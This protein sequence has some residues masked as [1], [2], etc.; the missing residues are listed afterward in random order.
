MG[1]FPFYRHIEPQFLIEKYFI[2]EH[3]EKSSPLPK[4]MIFHVLNN[5]LKLLNI[6]SRLFK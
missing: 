2:L 6:F 5:R 1:N 4:I 3:T